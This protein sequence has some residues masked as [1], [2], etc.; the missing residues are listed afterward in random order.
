M[1]K[2][3]IFKDVMQIMK[4]DSSTCKEV[5][6]ADPKSYMEKIEENMSDQEFAYLVSSYLATFGLTGHLK[7]RKNGSGKIPF[8]VHDDRWDRCG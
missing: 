4:E 2:I 8:H 6:G 5:Q 1:K 7:F 3:D